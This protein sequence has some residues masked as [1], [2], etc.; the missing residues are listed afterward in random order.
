MHIIQQPLF[1]QQ[2]LMMGNAYGGPP[3]WYEILREDMEAENI[4]RALLFVG[5]LGAH[6]CEEAVRNKLHHPD[7]RVRAWACYAAGELRDEEARGII[8]KLTADSSA[9]VRQQ[10]RSS[11][12]RLDPG[13]RRPASSRIA[14]PSQD[15][16]VLI[17]DDSGR[18][19]DQLASALRPKGFQLAF[20]SSEDETYEMASRLWPW[21]VITDNQKGRDNLSGLRMTQHLA[22]MPGLRETIVIMLSADLVEGAF[23]W[24]GG[25]R[26]LPKIAPALL[27]LVASIED[28]LLL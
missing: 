10:A 11:L 7:S 3:F 22:S 4:R 18:I 1:K 28:F 19:Q 25:D 2:I 17:S 20:A 13:G 21:A 14:A 5:C 6:G 8:R 15:A 16:L 24:N 9:R 27:A 12:H 26:F 23:L